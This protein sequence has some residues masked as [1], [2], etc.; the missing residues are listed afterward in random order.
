MIR[1]LLLLTGLVLVLAACQ[2]QVPPT[3]PPLQNQ[4]TALAQTPTAT[5]SPTP[6]ETPIPSPT[7]TVTPTPRPTVGPS[8]TPTP[9]ATPTPDPTLG[10][11]GFCTQAFGPDQDER[12]SAELSA[13][14]LSRGNNADQ[15]ELVFAPRSGQVAGTALCIP[16]A[17]AE[18]LIATEGL[19]AVVRLELSQWLHDE[20][21]SSSLTT[22]TTPLLTEGLTTI[23]SVAVQTQPD[24]SAGLVIELGLK[25]PHGFSVGLSGNRLVLRVSDTPDPALQSDPLGTANGSPRQPVDPVIFARSGDLW[26]LDSGNVRAITTTLAIESD[27]AISPNNRRVA[28]CRAEPDVL[29]ELG[30]LWVSDLDGGDPQLLA[31]VGGCSDPAWSVDGRSVWFVAPWSQ[32]TPLNYRLWSVTA[33]GGE[34]EARSELDAWSRTDPQPL[35][36]GEVLLV[37]SDGDGRRSLLVRDRA[38]RTIDLSGEINSDYE[39]IGS[40]LLAPDGQSVAVEALRADGGADLLLMDPSDGSITEVIGASSFW[41]RPLAWNADGSLYYLVTVCRAGLVLG[42]ELHL[43]D[44]SSDETLVEGSTLAEIGAATATGEGLVYVRA[45]ETTAA[46]RGPQPE[47]DG[48]S[49]LWLLEPQSGGRGQLVAVPD[50]IIGVR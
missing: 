26:T 30:Q 50:T 40:A 25:A 22:L 12:F 4:L 47:L 7:P 24:A 29:P 48:A 41:S 8:P 14:E 21:W 15:L 36:R 1:R 17:A 2:Q 28:F 45:L 46:E 37:G 49:T 34:P 3:A 9:E 16:A 44:G 20:A 6:T 35:P 32:V 5:P 18:A 13:I 39:G 31:D 43:L 11:F 42:Y 38:G 10:S 23:Q 33:S 19:S 27:F